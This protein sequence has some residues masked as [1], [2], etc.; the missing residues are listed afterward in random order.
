MFT[1]P[2]GVLN[3]RNDDIL[4][5]L[6]DRVVDEIVVLPRDQLSHPFDGLW[7]ADVRKAYQHLK[8]TKDGR[9]HA[10]RGIRIAHEDV[11]GDV[12]RSCVARGV[13]RSFMDRS[14]GTRPRLRRR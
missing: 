8:G 12:F 7:S 11:F 4:V 5:W 14:G 13:K 9:A 1:F 6:V 10:L 2:G 3:A